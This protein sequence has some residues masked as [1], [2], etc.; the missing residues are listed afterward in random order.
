MRAQTVTA[1]L[2]NARPFLE[3]SQHI[4]AGDDI[5]LRAQRMSNVREYAETAEII[6]LGL[7][8]NRFITVV[9][10]VDPYQDADYNRAYAPEEMH[11]VLRVEPPGAVGEPIVIFH[12]TRDNHFSALRRAPL[13]VRDLE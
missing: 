13:P 3:N 5:V 11:A 7:A 12:H 4:D 10:L 8:I 6:A 2:T 1:M 9:T